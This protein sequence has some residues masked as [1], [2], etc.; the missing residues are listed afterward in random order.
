MD[1]GESDKASPRFRTQLAIGAAIAFLGTLAVYVPTLGNGFVNWDDDIYVTANQNIRAM[2]GELARYA[3]LDFHAFN[4]HPLTWYSHAIDFAIWGPAPFGHHLTSVLLHAG[5][6]L[7]VVVLASRVLRRGGPELRERG[8]GTNSSDIPIVAASALVGLVFGLHPIH[9][10]SAA[11]VAE[12]KD[13]LSAFFYLS[14]LIAWTSSLDSADRG[15]RG[16][17]RRLGLLAISLV[18]YLLALLAKPMAVS[19]PAVILILGWYPYGRFRQRET[20]GAAQLELTPFAALAVAAA[21]VAVLAQRSGGAVVTV[22][23]AGLGT[24]ALVAAHSLLAYLGKLLWPANLLPFYPH[25]Q[26]V[27][28]TSIPHLLAVATFAGITLVCVL[29]AARQPWWIASWL[30]FLAMLAPVLGIVQAGGQ[31]M[32]DRYMYLPSLPPFMLVGGA[33]AWFLE[34][35]GAKRRHAALGVGLAILLLLALLSVRQMGIWRSSVELWTYQIE[36]EPT[37]A[38]LAYYNRGQAYLDAGDIDRAVVDYS[39]AIALNPR[40]REALYNRGIAFERRGEPLRAVSDYREAIRLEPSDPRAHNNLGVALA[41]LGYLT[42][43]IVSFAH[44]IQLDP[45]FGAAIFNR[46]LT[47]ATAGDAE[48]AVA[49]FRRACSVGMTQA[50]GMLT[51]PEGRR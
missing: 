47:L 18:T 48:A 6:S 22:D 35:G 21:V 5:N 9:V 44:A 29:T 16:K 50:C 41:T 14:S 20:R 38:P 49:D 51:I 37:R 36:R 32:A 30:A 7:L 25:P 34:R 2:G 4:W 11:W 15:V 13:V 17:R 23:A 12:R 8:G 43:A 46:G 31:A 19:L 42:E 40:Y 10:E 33:V 27:P 45:Q 28:F 39:A 26:A 24:R 3:F 1:G